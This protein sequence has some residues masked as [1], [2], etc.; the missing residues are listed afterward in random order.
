MIDVM[1]QIAVVD[2]ILLLIIICI[3]RLYYYPKKRK[4]TEKQ[5]YLND[6]IIKVHMVSETE[7]VTKG[8][9]VHTAYVELMELLSLNLKVIVITNGEGWGN[10]FHSHTYG[11]YY[12]WKGRRYK[13]RR[14]MTAH[15]IPDSSK[16]TIPFWK[17]LY[18]LTTA[19]LKLAYSY[20]DTI[21]AI[22]PTVENEIRKLGVK[23]KIVQI[24]NPVLLENWKCTL[25][26]RKFA[27]N[28]LGIKENEKLILGVGQLQQRKGVEDFID[29]AIAMP[30]YSFVWVGGRPMGAFTEGIKRID[31][32]IDTAPPNITFAGLKELK[33][34]PS[35]YAAADLFLFPSYQEN[36][37]LA[38]LEAAA[39]GLPVVYRDSEEYRSLYQTN[40][41][42]AGT[43]EE[44][45]ELSRGLLT[46]ADFYN[47]AVS[48]SASLVAEFDKKKIRSEILELYRETLETY[49]NK[50]SKLI[51]A[52]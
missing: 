38:P 26:D 28:K 12:F 31:H 39:A 6:G 33:D 19:Y 25:D 37:P 8:Q 52:R 41:L 7:W 47:H 44:F 50:E 24:Y 29:M 14:I 36:C 20:A 18:P 21:I 5:Q 17:Q 34:M 10:I 35:M 16:G 15:V 27:R 13:G 3:K 40:Y 23:S 22:S 11:P 43:T 9:G 46:N 4:D 1:F 49:F 2:G 51:V 45:I 32:R 30:E 42:K 48:L